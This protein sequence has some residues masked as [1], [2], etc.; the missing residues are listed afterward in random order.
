MMKVVH[1]YSSID[2]DILDIDLEPYNPSHLSPTSKGVYHQWQIDKK[3]ELLVDGYFRECDITTQP[4]SADVAST[5]ASYYTKSQTKGALKDKILVLRQ[6]R[7]LKMRKRK[8]TIKAT[9]LIS[10]PYILLL[11]FF[12]SPDIAALVIV[13]KYN[14][15]AIL[16]TQNQRIG[17]NDFLFT[18]S[19]AHLL[20][21]AL[22]LVP[23]IAIVA[24]KMIRIPSHDH[25]H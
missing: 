10:L 17:I 21:V 23:Y 15:D 8:E 13:N 16:N 24:F 25:Q 4:L 22:I 11:S 3:D 2:T 18:G 6:N 1:K 19:V 7:I 12:C 9:A 20:S 14:C 5:I